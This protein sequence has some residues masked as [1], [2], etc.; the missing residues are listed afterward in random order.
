MK[1][2]DVIKIL[3]EHFP[4][5]DAYEWDNVGLLIGDAKREVNK[6]VVA[7]D[8]TQK[9]LELAKNIGAELIVA[10]H[11]VI[12]SPVNRI[13]SETG[14][15]KLLMFALENKIA[16]YACHTN[17]DK[18]KC[19]INQ[20][21]AELFELEDVEYLKEDG[22]GRIGSLGEET[23]AKEFAKC[24]SQKLNT[25]VRFCGNENNIIKKVAICSGAG[26]DC[27]KDAI[28]KD[29]DAII[30]GDTKYHQMLDFKDS[31]NI[32]D[33]GHYPTEIIVTDIFKEILCPHNIE[34]VKA[35]SCDAFKYL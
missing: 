33:A 15:G 24:V 11:P 35:E 31:I 10:H 6:V 7:L 23:C 25:L 9:V 22:L 27:V 18:G 3:E 12:F 30:T 13:T 29:A 19:G 26:G 14:E 8:V 2:S 20:R 17:C 34:V 32:I 16:V 28:T 4:K 21:L 1:I 5:E